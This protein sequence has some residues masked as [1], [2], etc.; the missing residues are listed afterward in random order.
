MGD[1]SAKSSPPFSSVSLQASWGRRGQDVPMSVGLLR[2]SIPPSK[3]P[4]KRWC[5]V[6]P[7]SCMSSAVGKLPSVDSQCSCGASDWSEARANSP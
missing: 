5:Q 2:T 1:A 7:P 6:L 3:L 4:K